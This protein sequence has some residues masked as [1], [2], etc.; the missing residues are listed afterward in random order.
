MMLV[1]GYW[2]HTDCAEAAAKEVT[3][4]PHV[5]SQVQREARLRFIA[6]SSEAYQ[7]EGLRRASIL[8]WAC[9]NGVD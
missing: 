2:V 3:P 4:G 9:L 8:P 5:N 1:A 7:G 6:P